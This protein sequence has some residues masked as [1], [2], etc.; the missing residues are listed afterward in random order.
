M[1]EE[2]LKYRSLKTFLFILNNLQISWNQYSL[3]FHM[4][5]IGKCH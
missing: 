5:I 3:V 2:R 1:K 4:E